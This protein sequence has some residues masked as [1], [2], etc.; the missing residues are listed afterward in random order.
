MRAGGHATASNPKNRRRRPSILLEEGGTRVLVDTTPDL[1]D[2]LIDA[3]VS[4]LDAI[5][6]TH[7]HA[8]HVH[9]IDDIRPLCWRTGKQIP[10]YMDIK[11]QKTSSSEVRLHVRENS[12]KPA[13]FPL[14]VER[15]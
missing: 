6:Y 1:H 14:A 5:I 2:Q 3:E 8:D 4:D 15:P 12:G 10:T 13:T 7:S 9:G 11:T